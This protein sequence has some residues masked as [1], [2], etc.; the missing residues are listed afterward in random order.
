M[1][2]LCGLCTGEH[3]YSTWWMKCMRLPSTIA[4]L[5]VL[6]HDKVHPTNHMV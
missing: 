5:S 3:K 6:Q 4:K 1:L 2:T